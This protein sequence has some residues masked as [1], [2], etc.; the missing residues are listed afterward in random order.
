MS[1]VFSIASF[2]GAITASHDINIIYRQEHTHYHHDY[3]TTVHVSK[4]T[5]NVTENVN[6]NPVTTASKE[7]NNSISD[8]VRENDAAIVSGLIV[9]VAELFNSF[10]LF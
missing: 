10:K 5:E 4:A 2:A 3:H 9:V 6:D 1:I 8:E 7:E